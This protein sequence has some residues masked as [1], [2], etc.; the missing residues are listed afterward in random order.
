M[1]MIKLKAIKC[2][3]GF[4][5]STEI[6]HATPGALYAHS[7]DRDYQCDADLNEELTPDGVHD[8]AWQLV[9]REPGK[10]VNTE[11]EW[12]VHILTDFAYRNEGKCDAWRRM[13][14]LCS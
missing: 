10:H 5:T 9:N 14:T 1:K 13:G 2:N 12:T 3:L 6:T 7:Y 8:I 11:A 4:V